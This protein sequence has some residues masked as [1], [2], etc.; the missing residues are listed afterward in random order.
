MVECVKAECG[1]GHEGF[2]V[3]IEYDS[4]STVVVVVQ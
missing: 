3:V 1:H 2:D 4:G